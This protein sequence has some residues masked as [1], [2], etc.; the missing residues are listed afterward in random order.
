MVLH[1]QIYYIVKKFN[2]KNGRVGHDFGSI[3]RLLYLYYKHFISN[4]E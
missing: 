1:Y 3:F 2:E 4:S